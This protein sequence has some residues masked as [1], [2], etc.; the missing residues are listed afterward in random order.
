MPSR[1][2]YLQ[3]C[4]VGYARDCEEYADLLSTTDSRQRQ[5]LAPDGFRLLNSEG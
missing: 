5:W 2:S 4:N 1:F 3:E